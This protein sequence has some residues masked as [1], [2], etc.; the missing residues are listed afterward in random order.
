[1]TDNIKSQMRKG[2]LDYCILLC[3][4]RKEAYT[5]DLLVRLK[6]A[7]LLVMEG[8]L[9]PLL[10]R[11]KNNG[12]LT[13]RWQESTEGPPRKYYDI[14]PDGRRML[15]ELENEWESI[16]SAVNKIANN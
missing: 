8:T 2:M 14:T 11:M 3:V 13:Y 7:G 6:E 1:M 16:T 15:Q 12:W 4:S 5:N 9:Y 10:S